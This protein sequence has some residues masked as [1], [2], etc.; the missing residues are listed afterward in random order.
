MSKELEVGRQITVRGM[1]YAPISEQGVVFL[2]GRLAPALGFCI[3]R[4]QIRFPDCLATRRGKKC[5]I[6]FE[7]WA[8]DFETHRHDPKEGGLRRLL[9]QRLGVP[10]ERVPAFRNHRTEEIR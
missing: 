4:V 3:E 10:S 5:R 2:F 9:A 6:E 7:Y 1:T 8:S